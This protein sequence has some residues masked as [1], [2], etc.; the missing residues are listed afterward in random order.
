MNPIKAVRVLTVRADPSNDEEY[1]QAARAAR[2]WGVKGTLK[3]YSNSHGLC[4]QVEHDDG[5]TG[6]YEADEL[7]LI[8]PES[9]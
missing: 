7:K 1:V 2:R 3:Q 5:T 4:F 9:R 8:D 6:C